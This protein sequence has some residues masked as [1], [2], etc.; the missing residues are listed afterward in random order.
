MAEVQSIGNIN[1]VKDMTTE[2]KLEKKRAFHRE[3]MKMRR[4]TD[5]KFADK[6]RASNNAHKRYLYK[7]DL[8]FKEK[9]QT[10][11]R[12]RASESVKY[13]AKYEEL[14]EQMHLKLSEK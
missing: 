8:G 14:L 9:S 5:E 6:E 13:K 11:N 7:N 12:E 1:K 4:A 2:E 10:Y 3:Y